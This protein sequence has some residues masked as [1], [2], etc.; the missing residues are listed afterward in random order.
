MLHP[1]YL[2]PVD[3]SIMPS[4]DEAEARATRDPRP[5]GLSQG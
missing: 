5:F 4:G 2:M 1:P 3:F